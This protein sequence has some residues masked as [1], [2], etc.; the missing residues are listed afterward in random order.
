MVSIIP[1]ERTPWDVISKQIGQNI[2][3]NLPGA[4]QKG[5]ER[6]LG[7]TALEKAEQALKEGILNAET[8]ERRNLN[9]YEMAMQFAKVGAANPALERALGPLMQ[10]AMQEAR[11]GRAFPGAIEGQGQPGVSPTTNIPAI[12]PQIPQEPFKGALPIGGKNAFLTPNPFNIPTPNEIKSES[13]RYAAA[14]NDPNAAAM[15]QQQLQNLSEIATRQRQDLEDLAI[16]SGEISKEETPRFMQVGSQFDPRNP[17][18]WFQKTKRAY[19]EVKSNDKKIERAF[20]PGIGQA[21]L[22]RNRDEALKKLIPSSQDQKALGLEQDLRTYYASQYM[23]P[24][25]IEEQFYPLTSEKEK[26]LKKIPRGLFPHELEEVSVETGIPKGKKATISYEEARERA[27]KELELM[28]NQLADF[29]LKNVDDNTSLL[30]LRD[31]L[32][33]KDYDWRQIGPAIREAQ[34]KGLKLTQKQSTEL[35]DIETNP[36]IQS[37]PDIFR[38]LSRIPSYLRGNK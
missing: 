14:V 2:S 23:S 24:T 16:K 11:V 3:Q 37:L 26:A 1:A 4:V 30:V 21:L 18:E 25:E 17:N 31:A 22:G 19:D 29:F 5:Y 32:W 33:N 15:R 36:P 13:E 35:P 10:T 12:T 34:Q 38:D 6:G 8:G 28:Q 20:I 9:P 27:P 7:L